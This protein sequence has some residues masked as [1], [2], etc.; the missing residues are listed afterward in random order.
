MSN[1]ISIPDSLKS[2]GITATD[3]DRVR[4]IVGVSAEKND[5]NL[6]D[7]EPLQVEF[8][9]YLKRLPHKEIEDA[10]G[11]ITSK[12]DEE[13]D[14]FKDFMALAKDA[15][16]DRLTFSKRY[17]HTFA[18][19]PAPGT[20]ALMWVNTSSLKD[21]DDKPVKIDPTKFKVYSV[22]GA[23]IDPRVRLKLDDSDL[24]EQVIQPLRKKFKQARNTA[25]SRLRTRSRSGASRTQDFGARFAKIEKVVRSL[26][27]AAKKEEFDV[28][29]D[30]ALK[31]ALISVR[32]ALGLGVK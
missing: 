14:A 5:E 4:F 29:T 9:A 27:D 2:Q 18:K 19:V 13:S 30:A 32:K 6:G 3:I 10:D 17:C 20:G 23:V 11:N 8:G 28:G 12:L 31:S 16:T 7:M 24:M 1:V 15:A 21:A 25:I 22:T 26:Y